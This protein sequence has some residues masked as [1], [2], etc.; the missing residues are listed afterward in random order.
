VPGRDPDL[1]AKAFYL[2]LGFDPLPA[3]PMAIMVTPADIR[4]LLSSS[5]TS[6]LSPIGY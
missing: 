5:T 1:T 6:T 4:Q 3:D 2:A